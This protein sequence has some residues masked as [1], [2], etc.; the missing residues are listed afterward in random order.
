MPSQDDIL[1]S[2]NQGASSVDKDALLKSFQAGSSGGQQSDNP[3]EQ[4]PGALKAGLQSLASGASFGGSK[5]LIAGAE[6]LEDVVKGKSDLE[7]LYDR[8][9][10]HLASQVSQEAAGAKFHPVAHYGGELVGALASPIGGALKGAGLIGEA[11]EGASALS[12]I[13]NAARTGAV[14]GGTAAVVGGNKPLDQTSLSDVAKTA[15]GGALL[16]GGLGA[17]GQGVS[18]AA[19]KVADNNFLGLGDAAKR[20]ILGTAEGGGVNLFDGKGLADKVSEAAKNMGEEGIGARATELSQQITHVMDAAEAEGKQADLSPVM[21][22]IENI[23]NDIEG[24]TDPKKKAELQQL[25]S[26]AEDRILGPVE[27]Q[28]VLKRTAATPSNTEDL[29]TQAEKMTQDEQSSAQVEKRPAN[30]YKIET[31]NQGRQAIFEIP[32]Q[33]ESSSQVPTS[34]TVKSVSAKQ[35]SA[36]AEKAGISEEQAKQVLSQQASEDVAEAGRKAAFKAGQ[37]VA[38]NIQEG[39][40]EFEGM[41]KGETTPV[42]ESTFPTQK[43]A[44]K[45]PWQTP[46]E[47]TPGG[48]EPGETVQQRKR[49]LN[50]D[51]QGKFGPQF[52]PSKEASNLEQTLGQEISGGKTFTP[53]GA[54]PEAKAIDTLATNAVDTATKSAA[55]PQG[56]GPLR[57]QYSAFKQA[58]DALNLPSNSPADFFSKTA[59]GGSVFKPDVIKALKNAVIKGSESAEDEA[60]MNIGFDFLKKAGVENIDE[61]KGALLKAVQNENLGVNPPALKSVIS[62]IGS[63][64][65]KAAKYIGAA[66]NAIGLAQAPIANAIEKVAP[67]TN[68][69]SIVGKEAVDYLGNK[70]SPDAKK[71]PANFSRALYSATTQQLQGVVQ[72]LKSQ[73]ENY[74]DSLAAAIKVNDQ[75]KINGVLF[76]LASNPKTR[77]LLQGPVPEATGNTGGTTGSTMGNGPR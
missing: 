31:D 53:G 6:G 2:F 28:S 60:K 69:P 43:P 76:V 10:A 22:Q 29:Q 34:T 38:Q 64:L 75:S 26:M 4:D 70:I 54:L 16:G 63:P 13:G 42:P 62:P 71:T 68:I 25:V 61:L 15:T 1:K 23:K 3:D 59:D 50:V 66:P 7:Q 40:G 55:Y 8:Y 57:E 52:V 24:M 73:Y 72:A 19:G 67:I 33:E 49:N 18:A 5:H 58:S 12:K 17:L 39:T 37:P 65:Y 20:Y 30:T 11:A 21:E 51:D 41:V 9:K 56:Y 74:A 77:E 44:Q 27:K 48:F 14:L 47:G 35:I 36:L 46:Q 32:A 45:T